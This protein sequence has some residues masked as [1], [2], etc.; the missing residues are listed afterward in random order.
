MKINVATFTEIYYPVAN[1]LV[2]SSAGIWEKAKFTVLE[3]LPSH[4]QAP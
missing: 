1:D 4:P 3:A 2:S